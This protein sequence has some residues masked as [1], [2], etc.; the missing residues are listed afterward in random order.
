M[1]VAWMMIFAHSIIPHNHIQDNIYGCHE[2]VHN[3]SPSEPDSS[4][5]AEFRNQPVNV[6]ICHVTDFL[7]KNLTPDNL[8]IHTT[9]EADIC[10][11]YITGQALIFEEPYSFSD[12]FYGSDFLRAPPAA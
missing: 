11:V 7:F 2:L 10:P 6:K 5:S 8:I 1:L 9:R 12:H 3:S 4:S